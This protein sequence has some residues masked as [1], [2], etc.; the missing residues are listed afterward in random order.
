MQKVTTGGEGGGPVERMSGA[1]LQV[2]HSCVLSAMQAAA[3]RGS[4][5]P[6]EALCGQWL[7]VYASLKDFIYVGCCDAECV[8]SATQII[9]SYLLASTLR[10]EIFTESR[11]T[12][13]MRL[14]YSESGSKQC[15]NVFEAFLREKFAQGAPFA[16]QVLSFVRNFSK[17]FASLFEKSPSLQKLLKELSSLM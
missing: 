14:M 17:S 5:A 9:S 16:D 4:P 2:I 10:D 8:H 3:A 6:Q 15:Q 13:A 12:G 1:E 7:D 11:L